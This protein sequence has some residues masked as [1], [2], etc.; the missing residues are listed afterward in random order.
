MTGSE[1][2]NDTN[3]LMFGAI[4]YALF[5]RLLVKYVFSPS[6]FSRHE[7]AEGAAVPQEFTNTS[8]S[9]RVR[10]AVAF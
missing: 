10:F 4:Q 1:P 3:T 6:E 5:D 9:H 2:D 8:T 7:R